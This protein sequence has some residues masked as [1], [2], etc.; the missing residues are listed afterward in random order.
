MK[1]CAARLGVHSQRDLSFIQREISEWFHLHFPRHSER[2]AARL[3]LHFDRKNPPPTGGFLFTMFPDQEPGGTGPPPEEPP[4]KWINF[5]GG[6][7]GGV[8][9]PPVLGQG[10]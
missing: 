1:R 5:G 4:P 3:G 6:S 9:F 8:L 10:T 7:S 2:Y